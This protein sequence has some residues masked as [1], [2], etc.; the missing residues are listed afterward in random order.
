MALSDSTVRTLREHR[1]AQAEHRLKLG[2]VYTDLDLIFADDLGGPA[3]PYKVSERIM[4]QARAAAFRGSRF[5]DLRHTMA[6]L[7]RRAGVH[8]KVVSERLGHANVNITLQTDSHLL[9]DMQRDAADALDVILDA[10][11]RA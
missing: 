7:A 6:T 11:Q 8:P 4:R 5:H 9:P 3:R 1:A 10:P 2:S